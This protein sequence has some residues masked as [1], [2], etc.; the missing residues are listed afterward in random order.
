MQPMS[1]SKYDNINT[2]RTKQFRAPPYAVP[3]A[4][5]NSRAPPCTSK[6]RIKKTFRASPKVHKLN[7]TFQHKHKDLGITSSKT[8]EQL[9]LNPPRN[10]APRPVRPPD[11]PTVRAALSKSAQKHEVTKYGPAETCVCFAR[12]GLVQVDGNNPQG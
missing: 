6:A 7:K 8:S 3:K 2:H 11:R 9:R 12:S 10:P 5:I 1:S 4:R